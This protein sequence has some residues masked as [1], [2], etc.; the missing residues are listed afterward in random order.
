TAV[1][2]P[3]SRVG[4]MGDVGIGIVGYGLMGRAHAYGYTAAPRIRDLDATP[5]LRAISG[6]NGEAVARA[7]ARYGVDDWTTDWRALVAGAGCRRGGRRRPPLACDVALRRVPRSGDPVRLAVREASRC[8]HH[9]RPRGAPD[10]PRALGRRRDRGGC[11]AVGDVHTRA[12][13]SAGRRRRGVVM[14]R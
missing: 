1:V 13:R 9:R 3:S 8:V 6:R 4:R 7:A 11:R 2:T 10:R 5:R 14:P 12:Q